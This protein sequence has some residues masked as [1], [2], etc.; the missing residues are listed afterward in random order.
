[1]GV[2]FW[3]A[4]RIELGSRVVIN[5]G[6]VLDGRHYG[7][8]IG[9]DVS[10]GP[11]AA[12]LTL[13]HDPRSTDF[14]NRGGPVRIERHAWVAYRAIILPGVTVGEGAVVGAGSVVTKDVPPFAIVAGVPARIV[15]RRA[16][17][18]TYRL[19]YDPW[20]T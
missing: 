1:M 3:H 19:K 5:H 11:E 6:S 9:D 2:K 8:V 12:I 20:L 16:S 15:G 14:A 13:G 7:I 4:P 10:I 17:P 18:L